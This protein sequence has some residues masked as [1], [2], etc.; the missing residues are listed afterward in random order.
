MKNNMNEAVS[1]VVG[2]MLMLVVTI[3]IAAVVSAFAGGLTGNQ[4]KT[5]QVS[6]EANCIIEGIEDIDPTDNYP[7]YG[8]WTAAN[9]IEFEN[10]GGDIFSLNNIN[11]QLQSS[12][13]TKYTIYP[14]DRINWAS[15]YTCLPSGTTNGG[16]FQKIGNNSLSDKIIAP[17][18]KFML[19]ADG[20]Y[21]KSS[22]QYLIWC[23][24]DASARFL[25]QLGEEY[26]Y[27]IIDKESGLTMTN[28][29]IYVI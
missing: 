23:P 13:K 3:I 19:Y 21:E 27:T 2:V 12:T 29:E 20:C 10:K 9:G 11:I 24:E 7:N 16:Y 17:G 14:S 6:I 1:P 15:E 8:G 18:D 5:P 4:E 22:I 26:K 28:G 25:V